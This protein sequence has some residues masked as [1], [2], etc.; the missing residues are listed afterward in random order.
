M[1][2]ERVEPLMVLQSSVGQEPSYWNDE[3]AYTEKLNTNDQILKA[4]IQIVKRTYTN[5][6]IASTQTVRWANI[7]I[8][9]NKYTW[10]AQKGKYSNGHKLKYPIL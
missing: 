4:Y 1:S 7:Q 3:M 2:T 5:S 6:Q 9:Y 8:A 10:I